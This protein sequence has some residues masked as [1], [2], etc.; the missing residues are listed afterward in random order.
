MFYDK[1]LQTSKEKNSVININLDPALP[2]QRKDHVV[3]DKFISSDESKSLLD[4]SL[5][6]V[7]QVSDYCCS[8]KTNTQFFLFDSNILKRIVKKIHDEGLIAILD[9]KLGDVGFSNDSA[10][11]WISKLGFDAFTFSPF[12]GNIQ[13]AVESAHKKDLGIIVLTLMSNPEAENVM[14]KT[15]VEG[16]PYYMHIANSVRETRA[17][18]CVVGLTGFV[19]EE[20]VKNIQDIVGDRV[21]FLM[22]GIGPQGGSTDNLKYSKNPLVS[23]GREVI[24]TENPREAVKKYN[25]L[26]NS[27]R[28]K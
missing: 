5:D 27:L 15:M 21:I 13:S 10:I 25:D 1:Y 8:I 23:L 16:R 28:Q 2:S 11:F 4:F 6:I 22:Q 7:E 14:V 12:S 20:H 17:D 18:G 9:H 19:K 24:F 26:F 3:P